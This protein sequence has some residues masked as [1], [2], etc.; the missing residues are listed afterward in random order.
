MRNDV[1]H[2]SYQVSVFNEGSL[3]AGP[4]NDLHTAGEDP[5]R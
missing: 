1:A 4:A 3:A 5:K 2:G